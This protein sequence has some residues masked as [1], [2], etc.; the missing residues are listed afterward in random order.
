MKCSSWAAR[1]SVAIL[2]DRSVRLPL[3][4]CKVFKVLSADTEKLRYV[5]RIRA[6]TA[7]VGVQYQGPARSEEPG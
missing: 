1:S 4:A 3:N 6:R 5:T 2:A 7:Q